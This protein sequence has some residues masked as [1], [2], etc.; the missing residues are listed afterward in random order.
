MDRARTGLRRDLRD[1]LLVGQDH[2]TTSL[3]LGDDAHSSGPPPSVRAPSA[4]ARP[5]RFGTRRRDLNRSK[6]DRSFAQPRMVVVALSEDSTKK[7]TVS[8]ACAIPT[9]PARRRPSV[10]IRSAKA[11]VTCTPIESDACRRRRAIVR[12]SHGETAGVFRT[13]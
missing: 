12:I 2:L 8:E 13:R 11:Y 7:I 6:Q 3:S 10:A 4:E 1:R 9:S 5:A